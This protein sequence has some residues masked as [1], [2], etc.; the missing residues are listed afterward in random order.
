MKYTIV[1]QRLDEAVIVIKHFLIPHIQ[2]DEVCYSKESPEIYLFIRS[3]PLTK[4]IFLL[5]EY[6]FQLLAG[7]VRYL[8]TS[9]Y[10]VTN[11][12]IVHQR[13]E[14]KEQ[15]MPAHG[16]SHGIIDGM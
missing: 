13:T 6:N 2:A 11:V 10:I 15:F 3:L 1:Y 7:I 4:F 9:F 14:L 8:Q 12:G 16:I 5:I